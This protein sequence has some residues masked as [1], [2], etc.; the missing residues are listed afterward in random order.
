M[1]PSPSA[2][3]CQP[4]AMESSRPTP[5]ALRNLVL[6]VVCLCSCAMLPLL[7]MAQMTPPLESEPGIARGE[8]FDAPVSTPAADEPTAPNRPTTPRP[9]EAPEPLDPPAATAASKRSA[10]TQFT[11]AIENREP[12]DQITFV[13]ND[14][15]RIYFFSDLRGFEGTFV[16]HRWNYGGKMQAEVEFVVL[17]PRWR[18]WSTKYLDPEALGDWTV[19]I[20][21]QED[22]ILA[23][24][25][26]TYIE[27]PQ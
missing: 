13:E 9:A 15:R 21:T 16:R 25:T 17:G 27:A 6:F 7:A 2:E 18:V 19:E 24:E 12:I 26:F 22:E 1:P 8:R 23:S 4:P 5:R 20:V 3:H 11:T 10:L 14:V